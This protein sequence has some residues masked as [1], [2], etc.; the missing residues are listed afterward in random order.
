MVWT[1]FCVI[2]CV[3]WN[4]I[5]DN[6]FGIF[7]ASCGV[8]FIGFILWMVGMLLGTFI[9]DD[10]MKPPLKKNDLSKRKSIFVRHFKWK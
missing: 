5:K 1:I 6:D 8:I 10:I 7:L 3:I 9:L 4:Y 2:V